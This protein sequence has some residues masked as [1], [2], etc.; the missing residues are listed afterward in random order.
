M[1]RG[2]LSPAI[3]GW[4]ARMKLREARRNV[5]TRLDPMETKSWKFILKI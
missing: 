2:C 4:Y 3:A 1:L 5:R